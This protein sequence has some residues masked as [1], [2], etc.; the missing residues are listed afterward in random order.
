MRW[1][2]LTVNSRG[3]PYGRATCW[4]SKGTEV[5]SRSG[6]VRCGV[7]RSRTASIRTTSS[8]FAEAGAAR[9]PLGHAQG[10]D[11]AN[12]HLDRR[13]GSAPAVVPYGVSSASR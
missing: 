3:L 1:S 6:V 5:P 10:C 4:L 9:L 8:E 13:A 2:S 12:Q 11:T 7:A